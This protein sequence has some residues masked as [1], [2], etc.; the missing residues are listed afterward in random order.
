MFTRVRSGVRHCPLVSN[1]TVACTR[2][3]PINS[4]SLR[5]E[6]LAKTTS[7][8]VD[9]QILAVHMDTTCDGTNLHEKHAL[10]GRGPSHSDAG[11]SRTTVCRLSPFWLHVVTWRERFGRMAPGCS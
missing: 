10:L 2:I 5:K 1:G 7:T 6:D 3:N 4:S 8:F 9:G 11:L